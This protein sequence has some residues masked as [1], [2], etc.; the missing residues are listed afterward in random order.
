MLR[1]ALIAL[2]ATGILWWIISTIGW[3]VLGWLIVFVVIGEAYQL[4]TS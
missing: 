4:L 3:W 2:V 1:L